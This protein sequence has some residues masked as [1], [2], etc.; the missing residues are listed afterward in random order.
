MSEPASISAGIAGRYAQAAFDLAREDGALH[1]IETDVDS[2]E[3][4]LAESPELRA[5]I[6]SPIYSRD[7]QG[8]AIST[9]AA[10][11]GLSQTTAN[12]LALMAQ[13]RRLF[14]L[15]QLLRALRERLA[16]ERGEVSAEVTSATALSSDQQARLEATLSQSEGRRVR[17]ST[18]VDPSL[19]GG[20]VVRLGSREV[21]T[22]VRSRLNRLQALMREAP[23]APAAPA[24]SNQQE[25]I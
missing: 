6:D 14:V 19:I 1:R 5:L 3:A 20:L 4:A 15:P 22:S 9:V 24:R 11:M 16:R 10:R 8:R 23:A 13:K 17:V 21:D 18:R 25:V 2:L 7:E 12:L